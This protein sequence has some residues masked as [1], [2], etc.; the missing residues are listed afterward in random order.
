MIFISVLRVSCPF[1]TIFRYFLNLVQRHF[2]RQHKYY[3]IFNK[4]DVKVSY[5]CMPNVKAAINGHN[6]KLLTP[7]H[8]NTSRTCNCVNKETCPLNQN[9]LAK[10]IIYEATI[11]S[12]IPN[13]TEKK[14]IGLCEST[15]KKRFANHKSSF[16]HDT[17]IAHLSP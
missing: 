16:N 15:F 12:D 5:S 2:P 3:K 9:C 17:K 8:A 4:N 11:S 6:K 7:P 13:Y 10:S 1:W 14:Y